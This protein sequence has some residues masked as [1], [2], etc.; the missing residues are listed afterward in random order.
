MIALLA[1]ASAAAD[2]PPPVEPIVVTGERIGRSRHDTASSVVVRDADAI[3][4]GAAIDRI[5]Q[6]LEALPNV[7][8][9]SG[10]EG[11]TIRG[12]DSTGVVRDLPAFLGGNRPRTTIQVDGRPASYYELAFGS[13][14]L[15]D[16][17][18]I[19][20]FR[21]PQTTTQ[22]RNSIGG[23][24]FVETG[25]PTFE[26]QGRARAI[27]GAAA[28]RQVSGVVSGPLAGEQL[29]IR[30]A[31]DAR[32]SHTS[33]EITSTAVG[34]DPNVDKA[35][36]VRAKLRA[37]PAGLGGVRLDLAASHGVSQMP[38]FEGVRAPFEA[39]R[40]PAATYGIFR[41]GVDSLTGRLGWQASDSLDAQTTVSF[42]EARSRRF[43]PRGL[44]EARIVNRDLSIEPV[45]HWRPVG[46]VRLTGGVHYLR[47]FLDQTIDVSAQQFGKGAFVDRQRSLGLFGEGEWRLA[48]ALT[49]TAGLRYQRDR[50]VR[51]GAMTGGRIDLPVDYRETFDAWLPKLALAWDVTPQVR[52]GALVQRAYNPGGMTINTQRFAVDPFGA[53]RLWDI[54][55]FA[56]A[57]L[58]GGRLQLAANAFHY[59]IRDAQRTQTIAFPL[60]DGATAFAVEVDNAPRAWTRGLELEAEWRAG[61]RL[62]LTAALGLLE[63]RITQTLV[64][65]DP[66]LGRQFQRSPHVSASAAI[67]WRPWRALRLSADLRANSSYFSDDIETAARRIPGSATVNARAAF[68]RGP[69]TAFVYAR[70]LFDEF[71][72]TYRFTQLTLATLGD[73]R[74]MGV[75]V[76]WRF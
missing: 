14:G 71:H 40:D 44:G 5:E 58:L 34:I 50:Q 31:G 38:Q 42:G 19:E 26:W 76:D 20:V 61:P 51:Q 52:V 1:L 43:A 65:S 9:G 47:G 16:V 48:P 13:T 67:D 10:G 39:R 6:V 18:R 21:S 36:L 75:G 29:A 49:V 8:L 64:P 54:E 12:Q 35:A 60:A 4:R 53:E 57:R 30:I 24:I 3:E 28:T 32:R 23:A 37:E 74:E 72:L 73:P 62:G 63:T 22:G 45:V 69:L 41:I 68:G 17:D 59:A 27:A 2:S 70:N 56:R 11:P 66:L 33:S 15:W 25:A 55:A 46:P 7:Q